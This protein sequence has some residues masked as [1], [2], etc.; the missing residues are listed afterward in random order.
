MA[1]SGP[2]LRG[3]GSEKGGNHDLLVLSEPSVVEAVH[4]AYLEVG[5]DV[6]QTATFNANRLSQAAYGLESTRL[7]DQPARR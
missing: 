5:C 1:R 2:R 3:S 6:L 4:R 7:R